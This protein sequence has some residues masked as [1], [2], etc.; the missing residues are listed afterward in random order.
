[1]VDF[2]VPQ[3]AAGGTDV[4][5]EGAAAGA[6]DRPTEHIVLLGLLLPYLQSLG[7]KS[8]ALHIYEA[9]GAVLC[10]GQTGEDCC[11]IGDQEP[12]P[13]VQQRPQQI[14]HLVDIMHI[15]GYLIEQDPLLL[16]QKRHRPAPCPS[17]PAAYRDMRTAPLS[18][19]RWCGPD[20]GLVYHGNWRFS[21]SPLPGH[22][23]G[24]ADS[25]RSS[26]ASRSS[27]TSWQFVSWSI[28]WRP[29]G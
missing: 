18:H 2:A 3:A 14:F 1:M 5:C 28:S 29:P 24:G 4:L 11:V 16:F 27:R 6:V 21:S 7:R 20:D 15:I 19:A 22:R 12:D 9:E 8:I 17:D 25:F 26:Q 10:H 13:P 23:R